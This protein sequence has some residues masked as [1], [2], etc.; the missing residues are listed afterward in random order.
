MVERFQ[1]LGDKQRVTS[2]PGSATTTNKIIVGLSGRGRLIG[3]RL[4]AA[5]AGPRGERSVHE[6]LGGGRPR[7]LLRR[8]GGSRDA[9]QVCRT[10]DIELR[11]V[12]FSSEYW[13]TVFS[14]FIRELE[15]GNTPNPDVLCNRE[16]K[17]NVF[18]DYVLSFGASH[19]ATGHYARCR[20]HSDGW[21]LLKGLDACKDQTY[22]LYTLGQSELA[23]SVFPLGSLT[24]TE[25]RG[26]ARRRGLRTS[27][28]KDSTGICFIGE[29][30]F[31]TFVSRYV[32]Q[33]PGRIETLEGERLGAHDGLA[34]YT[35]GQ[36]QGLGIGGRSGT[37]G[38]PWYVVAKD[39]ERQALIVAQGCHH[40]MLYAASV[41]ISDCHW[42]AGAAPSTP[43]R[44]SGK[45]RYRQPEEACTLSALSD[46]RYQVIFDKPQWAPT[47]GQSLVLYDTDT[48]ECL[49]G[50]IIHKHA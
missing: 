40:P 24:K 18:L 50:G 32:A 1:E 17:F 42:I 35:L 36:R 38:E 21:R 22:F 15:D 33:R 14:R 41:E 7:R 44:C 23:R 12:N 13:D 39:P 28:K 46:R 10:L 34:F 9:E 5:R 2:D 25:V 29:R 11:T 37:S 47:P 4:A 30:P 16:I 48:E 19:L 31:K 3:R 43:L 26:L 6:E 27:E 49:G 45:T 20:P 8:R